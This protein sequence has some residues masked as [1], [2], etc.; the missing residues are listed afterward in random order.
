MFETE[1][2]IPLV[3]LVSRDYVADRTWYAEAEARTRNLRR[4]SA[5]LFY[6]ENSLLFSL[7]KSCS[8]FAPLWA[9]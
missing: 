5:R 3:D 2:E 6:F 1:A 8:A 4:T 7:S 9:R